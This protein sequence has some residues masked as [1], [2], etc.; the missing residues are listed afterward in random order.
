MESLLRTH[1]HSKNT[2]DTLAR[3]QG[4]ARLKRCAELLESV[5]HFREIGELVQ[6]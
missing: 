3:Q 6:Q 2:R 1:V 4:H 5:E